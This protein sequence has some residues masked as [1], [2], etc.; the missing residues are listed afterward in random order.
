[1]YEIMRD[2]IFLDGNQRACLAAVRS[3]GRKGISVHVGEEGGA[4]LAASSRYCKSFFEYPSPVS[5]PAEFLKRIELVAQAHR[6]ALLLPMTDITMA[7]ILK[8]VHRFSDSVTIP[9]ADY[10]KYSVLSDKERLF[11]RASALGIDI[12]ATVY[13]T[14]L[15]AAAHCDNGDILSDQGMSYPVVVKPSASRIRTENGWIATNVRYARS[16]DQLRAMISSNRPP[17]QRFLIQEKIEGPGV[18]IFLLLSA[19]KVLAKFSH[20][21]IREKP[22]SGGVSVVCRSIEPPADALRSAEKLLADAGW[23]GV[24]MVEFKRDLRDNRCKLMEVNARFWGSLQLAISAGIDFPYL[25]YRMATG[26]INT[27]PNH[28][29]LDRIS[30][31]ELGDLDHVIIRMKKEHSNLVLPKSAP[32]KWNTL[33]RFI[34]D[35]FRPNFRLEV[36]RCDDPRPFLHEFGQ[37]IKQISSSLT[38]G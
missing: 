21:R 25:L 9:F 31:W 11:R 20:Q 36:F 30:R 5:A 24:A 17:R 27:A 26:G 14:D 22:P 38:A 3:L 7:E 13:S 37:Y 4:S 32:S 19:G 8:N 16:S 2:V 18:G 33:A 35:F 28:Y 12:P 34:I 6:G 1:M 23:S 29:R 10:Q 15:D